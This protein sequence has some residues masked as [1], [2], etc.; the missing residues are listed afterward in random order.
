MAITAFEVLAKLILD[1]S[2]YEKGLGDAETKARG[3]GGSIGNALGMA[4]KTSVAAFGAIAGAATVAGGAVVKATGDVAS[5]G[6]NIDK[7]SQKMGLTA[8][9]Y[10]EWDAVM[11][12]SGTSMET[13]KASMKTLA[14]AAEKGNDAFAAL[15]ITED[16]L[17]KMNQQEIFEATIAG[18]QQ[19][20][21]DTQRTYLAGQLLGRGA[22][23]L[24]ALLNTSA[25]ET[26]AMRDRVHEL[27]GVMSD[28]AV[29]ASAK[30]QDTLQDMTTAFDGMKRG[31]V[32]DFLPAVTQGMEGLTSIMGGD[33]KGG[34]EQLNG[35][36]DSVISGI[37]EKLPILV[38]SAST[39]ALALADAF[40]SNLPKFAETGMQVIAQLGNGIAEA[41]PDL[42]V[43]LAES[44]TG[45]LE[46]L[47]NPDNLG[48][49][50]EAGIAILQ[51]LVDGIIEALPILIDSLPV[52]IDNIITFV[53]DSI[54]ILI[55]AAVQVVMALVQALPTIL[56]ALI[57][58]LPQIITSIVTGLLSMIG[59]LI[60]AGI[61]L[62]LALVEGLPEAITQICDHLP[63]LIDGL[64]NGILEGLPMIIDAG[65]QLFSAL[66]ENM[67]AIIE[68]NIKAIPQ[69]GK[70]IIGA[71]LKL[72]PQMTK[73]G[74]DLMVGLAKGIAQGAIKAAK[75]AI[76]AGKKVVDGVKKLFKINSPSKLFEQFG[77][78]LDEGMAIGITGNV[79]K[80]SNAMN[81]LRDATE[82][83][84]DDF[85]NEW[86]T[87]SLTSSNGNM[88]APGASQ[89]QITAILELDRVQLGKAI[90][91][92]NNEETQRIGLNLANGGY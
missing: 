59:E 8:E 61:Q 9:A 51:G 48:G 13:M 53:T 65:I 83:I 25:E 21:D 19:V 43:T 90:F 4:G 23:E 50:L 17:A 57:N 12:H 47:T 32:S 36:F 74:M 68:A 18:L 1:T 29:K 14:S 70:A 28:E 20:E 72:G 73:A 84:E 22:T 52:I 55:D 58:A 45:V 56:E 38:E 89:Q 2:E 66:V 69:L 33:M 35:A 62:F 63:E 16:Q 49:I 42:V 79:D 64:V 37:T 6:D 86:S 34:L 54:P 92:L 44:F 60:N 5:Y 88:G 75:A 27:G 31:I 81:E 15:G 80:V 67:P 85:G 24:G 39:I 77:Q 30:Y 76:D 41:L 3:M 71:I 46:T 82:P 78:Y 40:L 7:M 87:T 11:Q 26:Q 91:T 10:Q